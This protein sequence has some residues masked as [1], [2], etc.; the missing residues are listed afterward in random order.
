[1]IECRLIE[2]KNSRR[3]DTVDADGLSG[4]FGGRE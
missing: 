2:G 4:Y 3:L 1:M